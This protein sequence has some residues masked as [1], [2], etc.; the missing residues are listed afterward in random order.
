[1]IYGINCEIISDMI[2]KR[3]MGREVLFAKGKPAVDGADG[4]FDFYFNSDLNHRPTVKSDGSVDYWSVHSVEVVKKGQT[5]AN[6]CEPV[7]G[8]DGID[9]LGKVIA[10]KKG[11]GL[12]PL[13]G[14][15]FDK[16]VDGLTYT[17]AIDGKIERH[18]NRIIILP[19]LEINGDVDVGTGNI[20]FVGDVVI[21]G[22]V[23]TGARI[24]AAKSITIDGVCEG[25]VLEAGN[26]LILRKGMIGMGKARII[27]K[28]NL[29]AK[30]MEYTDVEV[31][32]FVEADSAINCNVVS[33]DKVIFNG[34]HASIV[35]GKVYGCAGIEV[36]NLGNDAFIKTEVH[37]GVHK[38]I[39]IKIAELEN[40]KTSSELEKLVDQKQM[41]LNNINAGIKQIEQMMGSAADGMNLEEKKLALVRAKIEKTAEL[42]EDKEELERL[43]GIVER[44]TGAT[45]QVLEHVYPNVE[46]CINNSKLVTKEEFDKI[47][48]KEKDKAVVMLSMK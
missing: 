44:S 29:F 10:A 28:G 19:I 22:S 23:K 15:G 1:V 36:Q 47:E 14:R 12:P 2:E 11:K 21:H 6:Y 38:K 37:V 5:I 8:E 9:V 34:G 41:L 31:D 42:T 24:R 27:V 7:A 17:A 35:G 26:D 13:V 16:S 40:K 20:D 33:N 45:V 32:G 18:K 4:Y 30:F 48:F 39:K 46:V 43:K 3:L 25:C